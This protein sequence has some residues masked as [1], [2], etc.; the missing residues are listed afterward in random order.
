[1]SLKYFALP[2]LLCALVIGCATVPRPYMA[3]V[4][5]L[6]QDPLPGQA[7][8]YLLRA[9]YDDQQLCVTL[10]GTKVAVLPGASYTAVSAQPGTHVLRT[11]SSGLLSCGSEAAHPFE[12]SL[13]VDERIFLNVSGVTAKTVGI[14]G[15]IPLPGGAGIP[16]LLPQTSTAAGTRTWK[17]VTELDA[18]GLMSISHLVMPERNAP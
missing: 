5:K 4:D 8:I 6:L 13:K 12:L 15:I 2:L 7:L 10:S 18:Q 9:P 14:T 17:K 16:L 11:Q 3:P 1:M